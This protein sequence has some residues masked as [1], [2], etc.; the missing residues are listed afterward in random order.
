MAGARGARRD[1]HPGRGVVAGR[2]L[3]L[4]AFQQDPVRVQSLS[5]VH[6]PG[7]PIVWEKGLELRC[8][9]FRKTPRCCPRT[10]ERRTVD[11]RP[12]ARQWR[13][14]WV[15]APPG[16]R[17]YERFP[18]LLNALADLGL[19][20]PFR[21]NRLWA[22][23]IPPTVAGGRG[24]L[25][26]RWRKAGIAALQVAAAQFRAGPERDAYLK[27]LI[28]ACH[29]EGILVYAWFELP[30]VSEKFWADHPEWES[31]PR[32]AGRATGLAQAHESHESGVFRAVSG[33]VRAL[34]GGSIGMASIWRSST[35]NRWRN[36]QPQPV[37]RR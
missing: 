31:R 1:S 37:S 22:S 19:D 14:L 27:G 5:D 10:L 28:E 25:R 26:A 20:P 35:S 12:E 7:L 4:P 6:R 8:S 23:S 21:S 16:E 32:W 3:R 17:G 33:G 9:R 34:V 18:Y 29:R 36:R 11:G 30:H 15:A 24:L 2:P 13:I